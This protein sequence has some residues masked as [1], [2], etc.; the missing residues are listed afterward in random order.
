MRL[1]HEVLPRRYQAV[2]GFN[3]GYPLRTATPQH[4]C[5]TLEIGAGL[6]EHLAHEDLRQQDYHAVEL[7]PA[8]AQALHRRFPGA[9][10]VVAD[11][12]LGLPYADA[13]F[14]RVIAIHVLEHLPDL[15][16]AVAELRRVLRPGGSLALV[17][18][19]DPGPTYWLARKI[20]AERLF[21]RH[22]RRPY[23]WLIRREHVNNP[24]EIEA[25]LGQHFQLSERRFFPLRLPLRAL[26]LCVGVVGR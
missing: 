18:P 25:V 5:R 21:R 16:R 11:C 7:R 17:Y 8:M 10:A 4:Y 20:S 13:S 2:E 1:W 19:C 12:Q 22:F 6:G 23:G 9:H 26:N 24:A 3:H 15:P 14:D